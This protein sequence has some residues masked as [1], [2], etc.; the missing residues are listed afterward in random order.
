M[1]FSKR[2]M[3]K[4]EKTVESFM[5]DSC[6]IT[7]REKGDVDSENV[8]EPGMATT[9]YTGK[10]RV[11]PSRPK[12]EVVGE[13]LVTWRDTEIYIPSDASKVIRDDLVTITQANDSTIT[14]RVFRVTDVR[15]ATWQGS[16]QL[17]AVSEQETS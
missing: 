17:S 3:K 6:T 16:R 9:I 12:E 1:A 8:Y 5:A 11:T 7:R 2:Q 10:C 13:E 15:A 14:G 4:I